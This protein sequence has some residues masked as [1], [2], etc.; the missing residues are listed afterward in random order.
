MSQVYEDDWL[1]AA[2]CAARTGL[3]IR[4]LRVYERY[5]L[6]APARRE[7]GYR[8]YGRVELGR[9]NTV[10]LLKA[11]GLTLA[12]IRDLIT[13]REPSLAKVLALQIRAWTERKAE[14]ERGLKLAQSA[15]KRLRTSH[16]LSVD[17]LSALVRGFDGSERMSRVITA[18]QIDFAPH[19]STPVVSDT[20]RFILP[21]PAFEDG[22]EPL[23]PPHGAEPFR[24]RSGEPICGRGIVFFNPDD[25]CY[26]VARGDGECV[27][28]LSPITARQASRLAAKVSEF[29]ADPNHLSLVQLKAVLHFAEHELEI[30]AQYNATRAF[31]ASALIRAAPFTGIDAF[32]LHRRSRLDVCYAV[33]VPGPGAFIG[34][35]ATPQKFDDGAVIVR[36]GE[37]VHLVQRPVFEATYKHASGRPVRV[38]HLAVQE[39]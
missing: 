20:L 26:E 31:V 3:T 19:R 39:P 16:R 6:I 1:N 8:R 9:L 11:M 28:I 30:A 37:D 33:F 22:G 10:T 27:I 15:L 32:G 18:D 34:P 36:H 25:H 38:A 35:A 13:Q 23:E 29:A 17:E 14:A 2:E 12:Q 7:N 24:D 21:V 4:A 5:Q